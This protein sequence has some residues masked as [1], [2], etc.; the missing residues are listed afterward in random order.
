MSASS[1]VPWLHPSVVPSKQQCSKSQHGSLRMWTRV[2]FKAATFTDFSKTALVL[3]SYL[4]WSANIPPA[5]RPVEECG[6]KA[7]RYVSEN[8]PRSLIV[9]CYSVVRFFAVPALVKTGYTLKWCNLTNACMLSSYWD[10]DSIFLSFVV[11][12]LYFYFFWLTHCLVGNNVGR[13]SCFKVQS[14]ITKVTHVHF[15]S[16]G[17]AVGYSRSC[18]TRALPLFVIV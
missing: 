17:L 7:I 11:P 18:W 9:L 5:W 15:A 2:H 12:D 16:N 1:S 10:K 3:Q 14:E 4:E 8:I 6:N 13:P